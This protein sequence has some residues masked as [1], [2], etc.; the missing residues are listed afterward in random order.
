MPPLA[1]LLLIAGGL[2]LQR[3]KTRGGK[4]LIAVGMGL[5]V[6]LSQPFVGAALLISLQTDPPLPA[7]GPLPEADAIVILGADLDPGTPELGG[8]SAGP[9]SLLRVRYG[10]LLAQR[11]GLPVLVTGGPPEAGRESVAKL[12]A[13][14]LKAYG[15]KARWREGR[16]ADTRQN[17]RFSAAILERAGLHRVLLVSHAWHLPRA[18]AAF[19]AAGLEVI[20]APTVPRTWPD[21]LRLDA[22]IP[23]VRALRESR[24]GLHEWLG[25]AWYALTR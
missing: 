7:Q 2:W 21:P 8:P 23:S 12:M 4:A 22:Y 5:F 18:R 25:R 16:A 13:D 3:R 11:S 15:V 9:L 17:A 20:A 19:E 6:L 1:P 10:A 24:F 14:A